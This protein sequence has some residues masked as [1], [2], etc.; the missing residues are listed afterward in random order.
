[1]I[2]SY[3]EQE[4]H[5]LHHIYQ[6]DVC[7]L[8]QNMGILAQLCNSPICLI[9]CCRGTA[10]RKISSLQDRIC[11]PTNSVEPNILWVSSA[12]F[13]PPIAATSLMSSSPLQ[14]N[15]LCTSNRTRQ[16]FLQLMKH[17]PS[18]KIQKVRVKW[19]VH[20]GSK[21]PGHLSPTHCNTFILVHSIFWST[22]MTLTLTNSVLAH[23]NWSCL[24]QLQH[25]S[26]P[27]SSLKRLFL[28]YTAVDGN[29]IPTGYERKGEI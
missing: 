4:W 17:T 25:T 15:A 6:S 14:Q 5:S 3:T 9:L 27:A 1:M 26:I 13:T 16:W 19:K 2:I 24:T 10:W 18:N 29:E 28:H 20:Q 21:K 22:D 11:V 8:K 23:A 7:G 12:R